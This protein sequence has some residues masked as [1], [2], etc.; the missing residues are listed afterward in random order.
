MRQRM[1]PFGDAEVR[2]RPHARLAVHRERDDARDVG[3]EGQ[4][5]QVEHQAEVLGQVVRR[6]D[7]RVRNLQPRHVLLRGHLHAPFDLADGVE[8]SPTDDAVLDAEAGLQP[9]RL[10]LYAIEDAA[11]LVQD[12]GALLVGV[13]VAEQLLEHRARVAFL[14]QRLRRRA[15]RQPRA[16]ESGRQL[17]RRNARFLADVAR[18]RAGRARR[19]SPRRWC[20]GPTA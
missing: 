9:R 15:P 6:A 14:R 3:L 12:R 4:R 17:E 13:A 11:R 2:V 7:R 16:A 5:H 20:R 19:P 18:Q 10:I 1:E 8:V